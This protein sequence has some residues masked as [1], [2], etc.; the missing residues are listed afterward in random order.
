MAL[1]EDDGQLVSM[2]ESRIYRIRW[3]HTWQHWRETFDKIGEPIEK[4]RTTRLNR[5]LHNIQNLYY[6]HGKTS[7]STEIPL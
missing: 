5:N 7:I 4:I 3:P 1:P 2:Q 6:V